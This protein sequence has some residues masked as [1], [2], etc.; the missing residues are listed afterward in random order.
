MS[1]LPY[2]QERWFEVLKTACA[3]RGVTT[4][5]AELG[6]SNHTGTSRVLSG[7]YGNTER[8]AARVL[9]RLDTV[10]CPHT[11]AN[12]A[13]A[14]CHAQFAAEPPTH[15]PYRLAHWH[16]CRRCAHRPEIES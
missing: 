9:A 3:E 1:D 11:G 7:R 13:R 2:M 10:N 12:E 15:N 16:A 14:L 8:F 6:F 4:V 5:A